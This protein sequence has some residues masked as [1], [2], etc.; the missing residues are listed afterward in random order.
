MRNPA[1]EEYNVMFNP[2]SLLTTEPLA[3]SK[4]AQIYFGSNMCL[5]P[6]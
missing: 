6:A 5:L 2:Y 3:T 1:G 4:D